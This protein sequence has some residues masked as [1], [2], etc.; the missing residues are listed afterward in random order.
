MTHKFYIK[1]GN[2]SYHFV[3]HSK[4]KPID[5]ATL[6]K[7]KEN[8]AALTSGIASST[9][10]KTKNKASTATYTRVK[11]KSHEVSGKITAVNENQ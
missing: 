4:L 5:Y 8:S 1:D 7:R 3:G 11:N 2:D 9:V 10:V 6:F